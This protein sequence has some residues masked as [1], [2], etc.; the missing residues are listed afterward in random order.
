M[1]ALLL[2]AAADPQE[3]RTFADWTVGCDNGLLCQAV[4]LMPEDDYDAAT[5]MVRRGPAADAVPEIA[6]SM[7]AA[8]APFV[9]VDGKRFEIAKIAPEPEGRADAAQVRAF[10]DALVAGKSAALVGADGK[11]I[12]AVSPEG[13]SAALLH[14]DDRQRR[15]GTTTALVRR[16][17]KPASA[18]PA[19][20]PL[21]V[22][23]MPPASAAPPRMA[24]P[25]A[26]AAARED[27]TCESPEDE[28]AAHAHRLDARHSL[29]L[30][31]VKCGSGAYNF[32]SVALVVDESGTARPGAFERDPKGDQNWLMNADWVPEERR[33]TTYNKGRGIGD[34]GISQDYAWDG[35]R[36]RLVHQDEMDDC[37]GS[38]DWITTW[39]AE[40]R[41]AR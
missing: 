28:E 23:V 33:L 1:L 30:V 17:D 32:L 13:A 35:A 37:R 5:M 8:E 10:L 39:R 38:L 16:G 12:A 31:P 27:M 22:V 15:V 34:C 21:P 11:R 26:V 40:T 24:S 14:M 2:A 4:G 7:A 9:E 41:T 25:A 6:F 19:P 29:V 20:P 3:L 36:F 18:V